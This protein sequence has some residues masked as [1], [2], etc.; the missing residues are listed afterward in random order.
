MVALIIRIVILAL[1]TASFIYQA[2]QAPPGS[3]KQRAYGLAAGAVGLFVVINALELF[4]MN[5]APLM[6]PVLSVSTMLLLVG[7]VFLY[8]AWRAGEMNEQ[9]ARVRE[10][11]DSE[12]ARNKEKR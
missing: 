2:R 1:F 6:L 7:V 4:G 11:V 12:R 5:T 9:I 3:H 8:R 10:I